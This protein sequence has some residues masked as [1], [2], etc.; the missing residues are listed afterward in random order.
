MLVLSM[1]LVAFERLV[2]D[3]LIA[4]ILGALACVIAAPL[5]VPT[6]RRP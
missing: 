6:E 2:D 3:L 5:F 4:M 1:L